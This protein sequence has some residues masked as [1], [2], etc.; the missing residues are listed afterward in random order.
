MSTW[1]R[2][3]TPFPFLSKHKTLFPPYINRPAGHNSYNGD[4]TFPFHF[5]GL[6]KFSYEISPNFLLALWSEQ[7]LCKDMLLNKIQI[8]WLKSTKYN[9]TDS[10]QHNTIQLV[11]VDK[12]Q[13]NW[14]KLTKYKL[15][16]WSWQNANQ[17]VVVDSMRSLCSG[18]LVLPTTWQSF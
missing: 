12:M 9:S 7:I 17:L 15:T 11:V 8:N 1:G 14:L 2:G 4:N 10:G 18:A 16:G 3:Q 13:I 6:E 5:R